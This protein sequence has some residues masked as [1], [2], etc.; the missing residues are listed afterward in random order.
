MLEEEYTFVTLDGDA[1]MPADAVVIDVEGEGVDL[2][3][4]VMIDDLG[5]E[6]ADQTDFI[7]F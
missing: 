3:D 1:V 2:G 7:S 4:A 5:F 6:A